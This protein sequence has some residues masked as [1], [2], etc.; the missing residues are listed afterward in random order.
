MTASTALSIRKG[1]ARSSFVHG[2]LGKGRFSYLSERTVYSRFGDW[3]SGSVRAPR[4]SRAGNQLHPQYESPTRRTGPYK[5]RS[6]RAEVISGG[7]RAHRRPLRLPLPSRRTS[8]F[9]RAR[10]YP[11]GRSVFASSPLRRNKFLLEISGILGRQ[12]G[13]SVL[14]D[15]PRRLHPLRSEERHEA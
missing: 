6:T 4:R 13:R 1:V 10:A 3:F 7:S 14:P 9:S 5:N 8:P 12:N 2:R 15:R 11:P